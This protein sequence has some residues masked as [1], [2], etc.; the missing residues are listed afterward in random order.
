MNLKTAHQFVSHIEATADGICSPLIFAMQ[1][2]KKCRVLSTPRANWI[3]N[4]QCIDRM[5]AKA[6]VKSTTSFITSPSKCTVH[7]VS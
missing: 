4:T 3:L 6:C 7:L 5:R 2:D 1:M